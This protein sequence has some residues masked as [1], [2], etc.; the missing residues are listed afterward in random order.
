MLLRALRCRLP[1]SSRAPLQFASWSG[2]PSDLADGQGAGVYLIVDDSIAT[3]RRVVPQL[4]DR[5]QKHKA[6]ELSKILLGQPGIPFVQAAFTSVRSLS[7]GVRAVLEHALR[8]RERKPYVIG[9]PS[10]VFELSAGHAGVPLEDVRMPTPPDLD[11]LLSEPVDVPLGLEHKVIGESPEM[12]LVRQWIV[13]AANHDHPVVI[14]GESGTGKEVVARAVHDLSP[15]RP[16]HFQPVNCGAIP[17][18]LFESQVFGYVPGAFSGALKA[19]SEGLWR[20]TGKGTLFLDEIGDLAPSHQVKLLRVLQENKVLPVGDKREAG[21]DARV[22]AATNRDLQSMVESGEFREDLYYRLGSMTITLPPLRDRPEDIAALATHFWK[23]IAPKRPALSDEVIKEL[24][25]YQWRGNARELRYVLVNLH[26][27]FQKS[28]PGVTHLRA[29]VRFT[30]P[31]ANGERGNGAETAIRCFEYLR[32]LRRASGAISACQHLVRSI[33]RRSLEP[34]R[35]TR[36]MTEAGGCLTELQL[37][38]T[39]PERFENLATFEATHKLAGALAAF[40]SLLA[41]SNRDA[42]RYGKKDLKDDAA[43]AKSIVRREEQRVLR[44]L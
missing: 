29:V 1:E 17:S 8:R 12:H 11:V 24:R 33:D 35:R 14:L 9:V 22:I 18:E 43:V 41:R 28:V 2:S 27:T 42:I 5:G 44:Q 39:R 19:G 31:R 3:L 10:K 26:T 15:R 36:L 16:H 23:E 13:R 34:D 40:Q 25:Q 21:V 30:G 20:S 4:N 6:R 38:G 7:R 37:L 32:H